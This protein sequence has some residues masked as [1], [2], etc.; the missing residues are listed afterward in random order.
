MLALSMV[1]AHLSYIWETFK[2]GRA[3]IYLLI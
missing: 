2:T 3:M 1:L